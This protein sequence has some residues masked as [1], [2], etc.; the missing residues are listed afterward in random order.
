MMPDAD[1]VGQPSSNPVMPRIN[2][3]KEG[4]FDPTQPLFS[5]MIARNYEEWPVY[6]RSLSDHSFHLHQNHVLITKITASPCRSQNG[7]TRWMSLLSCVSTTLA[8][9]IPRT[10]LIYHRDQLPFGPTSIR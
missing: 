10:S 7:T 3:K 8:V 2:F 4:L 5:D 1:D 6:N 9:L